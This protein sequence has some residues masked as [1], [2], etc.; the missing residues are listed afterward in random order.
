MIIQIFQKRRL[1]AR[2]I[3][4]AGQSNSVGNSGIEPSEAPQYFSS[5]YSNVD[6]YSVKIF[7]NNEWQT[8]EY[9]TNNQAGDSGAFGQEME[10][11]YRAAKKWKSNIYILKVA[12]V[13]TGLAQD[14]SEDDWNVNTDGELY[15]DLIAKISASTVLITE[16]WKPAFMLWV[17]GERDSRNAT[18]ANA[19]ATNLTAFINGIRGTAVQYI[20]FVALKLNDNIPAGTYPYISTIRAAQDSTANR[21][22]TCFTIESN[23]FELQDDSIHYTGQGQIDISNAALNLF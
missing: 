12:Q 5:D 21:I 22:D 19:Y 15:D 7:Y 13:S 18:K 4:L 9:G 10:I 14:A 11:G 16:T 23:G 17:Q 6:G 3:I 1:T 2:F 8:L 20:P